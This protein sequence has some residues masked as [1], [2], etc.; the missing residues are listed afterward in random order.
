MSENLAG[1]I[2]VDELDEL[3]L[4]TEPVSQLGRHATGFACPQ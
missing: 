1:R 4:T 2:E 3:E